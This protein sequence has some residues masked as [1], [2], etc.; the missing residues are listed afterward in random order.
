MRGSESFKGE[1]RRIKKQKMGPSIV[2][3]RMDGLFFVIGYLLFRQTDGFR[4]AVVIAGG[5]VQYSHGAAD[6]P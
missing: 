1:P 3:L 4:L 2:A 5:F 6:L